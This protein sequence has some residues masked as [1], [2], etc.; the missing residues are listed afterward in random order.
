MCFTRGQSTAVSDRAWAE[1][2]TEAQGMIKLAGGFSGAGSA[3]ASEP[4]LV[5]FAALYRV[6]PEIAHLQTRLVWKQGATAWFEGVVDNGLAYTQ[7]LAS[8][9]PGQFGS[10]MISKKEP[11]GV[12]QE[13]RAYDSSGNPVPLQY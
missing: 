13:F 5:E 1:R 9:P 11:Y 12:R 3:G 10:D 4:L 7:S 2:P 8:V 6:R